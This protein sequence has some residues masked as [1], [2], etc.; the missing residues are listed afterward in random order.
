MLVNFFL[1][2]YDFFE[3][4]KSLLYFLLILLT[5]LSVSGML[6]LGFKEDISDF[7][8]V[9]KNYSKVSK[10]VSTAS[11]NSRIMIFFQPQDS[12]LTETEVAEC[13]DFFV[14]NL[15]KND[16][17]NLFSNVV[18]KFDESN[19]S[20]I[21][22]FIQQKIPYFLD[23]VS[24]F[25]A[26][27]CL[28]DSYVQVALQTDK[29]ILQSPAP[30][31]VKNTIKNDPLGMFLPVL[32]NLKN[33]RPSDKYSYIN[34]H[35]FETELNRGIVFVD[36]PAGMSES[37]VNSLIVAKL[38]DNIDSVK[39]KFNNI[40]ISLFGAP[41]IAVGNSSRIKADTI[42]TTSISVILILL[43]LS[44]S[45]RNFRNMMLILVTLT[46][47][48]LVSGAV[49]WLLLGKVSLISIGISSIFTGIA[50]NYPLHFI[51]HLYHAK[52]MRSN[53]KEIVSPLVI[54]NLTTVFAFFSL[55]FAGSNALSDLGFIGGILLTASI[56]FTLVF[57]PHFAKKID[58]KVSEESKLKFSFDIF[59]KK[60]I[61]VPVLIFTPIL[62]YFSFQTEFDSDLH[63]INYMTEDI[64]KESKHTFALLNSDSTTSVFV[65]AVGSDMQQALSV[66]EKSKNII[67][68]LEKS[69]LIIKVSGIGNFIPSLDKQVESLRLWNDYLNHNK[70][71]ILSLL[72]K[73]CK[74]QNIKIQQFN[75]FIEILNRDFSTVNFDYFSPIKSAGLENYIHADSSE[76]AIVTIIEV[77]PENSQKIISSLQKVSDNLTVY[78]EHIIADSFASALNDNFNYVLFA[79]GFI[80]FVFL[81]F[82]FGSIELSLISFIPLTVSWFWI[83][84]LMYLFDVKFNIVNIILATF[85][86]GQGDDYAVFMTEGLIYEFSRG[87]KVLTSFK[88]A[89]AISSLIM[90]VGVGTL[91][92]AKHPAMS[93]LGVIVI[94]GMFSVVIASYIFPPLIFNYLTTKNGK[95]RIQPYTLLNVG[96]TFVYF[97]GF[98]GACLLLFVSAMYVKYI[99]K[100]SMKYKIWFHKVLKMLASRIHDV[101]RC[102]FRIVNPYN[103]DFSKPSVIIAN[104][105]SFFDV[106]CLMSLTDKILFVTN[107]KQQKN[108]FYGKVLKIADFLP[109]SDGFDK[110]VTK[111]MPLI[112]E[113]FSV[114]VFPE[115]TRSDDSKIHRFHQG[116]FYL[117]KHFGVD[118][119]PVII[120][121]AGFTF[122]KNDLILRPGKITLTIDKRIHADNPMIS[123][124][125]LET[126]RNIRHYMIKRYDEVSQNL[127]D[128]NWAKRIVEI[129]Y[130]Y[131]GS[132]IRLCLNRSLNKNLD[133]FA[134]QTNNYN[135]CFI[136]CG[137]GEISLLYSLMNPNAKVTA[138]DSDED[139]ILVANNC[140]AKTDNLIYK[141]FTG[142]VDTE[143]FDCVYVINPQE[144][145]V[146]NYP[147]AVK[148]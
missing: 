128:F 82:S 59:Q 35:I 32:S 121:G 84:G 112:K 53:I 5:A 133:I 51:T 127:Q 131:K 14:E 144:N 47:G 129:N 110:L 55:M 114:V 34:G 89:I 134:N 8:P 148:L 119:L 111:L 125:V 94:I 28:T 100:L 26:D 13:M 91:I 76:V 15:K 74:E 122:A 31:L 22:Q 36:S 33:F 7:L 96:C 143:D 83:L 73:H 58:L 107:D 86:F 54:G 46:F 19:I 77:K 70:N 80:V 16:E 25:H 126:T 37:D 140:Q 12:L 136:N 130:L 102:P 99:G 79:A 142:I 66:Y 92:F 17:S 50:V 21:S 49:S 68:S 88:N 52:D 104:H 72:E 95:P 106:L 120:H 20:R 38:A 27:S 117:A 3:K 109:A 101:P 18:S 63:N 24:Y 141:V 90:F 147:N 113:G 23:S 30:Q 135:V 93:S 65:T 11:G 9:G 44:F 29:K 87:K 118:I 10:F 4:R 105:S 132:D 45:I 124:V 108:F 115:G 69:D 2:I 103:E 116:A 138:F 48:F 67:D 139:K 56:L 40:K 62:V 43:I 42:L 145:D 146:E 6:C 39:S 123:P 78:D 57:L 75:P 41:V 81:M 64:A 61:V 71:K 98:V 137:Y 1:R 85:I 60:I 97:V